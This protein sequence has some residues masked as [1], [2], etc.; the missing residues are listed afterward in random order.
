MRTSSTRV[1]RNTLV[2]MAGT[3]SSRVL[4]MVRQIVINNL[5]P[6]LLTDAFNYATRIPNLFRELVAE[7]A[8][9]NA[10]I[11][12]LKA[13]PEAEGRAFRRRFAALLLS[14]NLLLLG[15]GLLLAPWLAHLLIE[16]KSVFNQPS[17]FEL[18]VYQIRLVV[19]FLLGISMAALFSAF[20]QSEERFGVTAFAPIALNIVSIIIML[21]WPGSSTALALSYTAG[22]FVQALVQLPALKGFALEWKWHPAIQGALLRMGPFAFTTSLRQFLNLVLTN[23]L[24]RYPLGAQTGFVSAEIVFQT[25]MGILA[26]S[27]A[28]AV[29][30]RLTELGH[31]KDYAAM[32][33]LLRRTLERLAVLLGFTGAMLAALAPWTV[34]ALYAFGGLDSHVRQYTIQILLAYG[35][36]L[37]PWGINQ[38]MLRAFYA[39]G[40]IARAVQVSAVVFVLNILGYWLLRNAGLFALNLAT[41]VAGVVG[42]LIYALRLE[43]LQILSLR[44]LLEFSGRVALAAIPSGLAA[45]FVAR[46]FGFP[47]YFL[48][49]LPPLIAGG[50]AGLMVFIVAARLLRLPLRL[51]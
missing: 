19:P 15:L 36:A 8:V 48:H 3:L 41:A 33:S 29:Y 17:N 1:V 9:T 37:L 24:S 23:V 11:P 6:P 18:L 16:A 43:R 46:L 12:V 10:L 42:L 20:L 45:H 4:G 2:V 31:A 7:G 21:I 44:W 32:S 5:F 47:G 50:L 39:V 25:A 35:F 38:I 14:V 26:V 27:P 49:N 30:P 13:L 51:R 28:M 22:A 34:G 40:E